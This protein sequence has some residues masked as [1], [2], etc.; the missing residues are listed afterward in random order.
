MARKNIAVVIGHSVMEYHGALL[1]GIISQA[2]RLDYN[3]L[4]F[5]LF[6]ITDEL[7]LYQIG[8]ENIYRLINFNK[9]DGIVF[10]D[11]SFWAVEMRKRVYDYIKQN[12]SGPIVCANSNDPLECHNVCV[13]E[14]STMASMVEHLITC[15]GKKKIYCLTGFKGNPIAEK[16]LE[17]Y[18]REM[19]KHG[20]EVKDS[21]V[22]YGDFWENAAK[23]LANDIA[24]GKIERPEAVACAND[25]MALSL[26]N[27]LMDRGILVPDD[28]AVTGYD[29][30]SES[31]ENIPSVTT[32]KV[33]SETLGARCV[34]AL[35]KF[36]TG[37]DAEPIFTDEGYIVDSE[38]CGCKKNIT[39][40][41]LFGQ[42]VR[43]KR[44]R[45]ELIHS[46]GMME[47]LTTADNLDKCLSYISEH[48]YLLANI[49]ELA[50]CFDENWNTFSEND[51]EYSSCGYSEYVRMRLYMKLPEGSIVDEKIS[52]AD[53]IPP[54]MA[55]DEP[56]CCYFAPL[57]FA[58]RCFGYIV[59]KYNN[60]SDS[61]DKVLR[62]WV[63]NINT[64]LEYIRVKDRYNVINNRLYIGSLRDALTG[65]YNRQ[66]YKKFA[67]EIFRTAREE[68]KRLLLIVVDL[69][70][71]KYIND[72]FGHTEGDNAITVVAQALQSCSGNS[73][74][75]A[76]TGGDEFAVVGC[77]D[78]VDETPDFYKRRI[79]G[80]LSRYNDMSHKAYVV[81][82]SY[83]CF[84][85]FV[86][87]YK[88]VD[89]CYAIADRRM[90]QNKIERRK[91]RTD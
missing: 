17:A 87:E 90:Y 53:M 35:H 51:N 60:D 89:E 54:C 57:H 6:A 86:D 45:E 78:Y 73:E 34:C 24:D 9:I 18:R 42:I 55:E 77:Y 43:D 44:T 74:K 76:R 58:D 37:E 23:E 56:V 75:C 83:G 19:A 26:T 11:V 72:S 46:S 65:I 2:K 12:F 33:S 82:A 13:D 28:I 62:T 5:S 70:R 36:I 68:H 20:L 61:H 31:Y 29:A 48:I 49:K 52:S 7:S 47:R 40:A 8:E 21:Y 16:R 39:A 85:G 50:L 14:L 10:V 91:N 15:H 67:E 41:K 64:A 32:Y 1:H 63:K 80:Y 3:V 66:G 59:I 38:S 71:L 22:Y 4:V 27:T 81:E 79:E 69:D 30:V 84:C 25:S 88:S